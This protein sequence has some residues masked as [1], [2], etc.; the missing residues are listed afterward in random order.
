MK[1]SLGANASV[2]LVSHI[3][4]TPAKATDSCNLGDLVRCTFLVTLNPSLVFGSLLVQ[5][6]VTR[7]E[8]WRISQ[9]FHFYRYG[10]Q[11]RVWPSN[12]RAR[13]CESLPYH[14]G[15]PSRS[16]F[17]L[18]ETPHRPHWAATASHPFVS[19]LSFAQHCPVKMFPILDQNV[20]VNILSETD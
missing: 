4:I 19:E 3:Y 17:H 2:P 16:Q 8:S 1:I 11:N 15:D 20:L 10:H 7:G 13:C 6:A 18:Y 5:N 14:S 12:V 9:I